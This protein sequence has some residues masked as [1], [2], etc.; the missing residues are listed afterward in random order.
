MKA[1]LGSQH[2]R[3]HACQTTARWHRSSFCLLALLLGGKRVLLDPGLH[4]RPDCLAQFIV[5][6]DHDLLEAAQQ[7]AHGQVK[8]VDLAPAHIHLVVADLCH[9]LLLTHEDRDGFKRAEEDVELQRTHDDLVLLLV[10]ESR[11]GLEVSKACRAVPEARKPAEHLRKVDLRHVALHAVHGQ[12]LD[13]EKGQQ[14]RFLTAR[15]ALQVR[16]DFAV[17][18]L[19]G[20]SVQKVHAHRLHVRRRH[21]QASKGRLEP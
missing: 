17:E 2:D 5:L 15:E 19:R 12:R 10:E 14:L 1:L 7:V 20:E 6:V 4:L 18:A 11:G 21:G 8:L 13:H 16:L 3:L 9:D